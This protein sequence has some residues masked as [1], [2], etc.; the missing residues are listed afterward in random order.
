V[1]EMAIFE[2]N[3][4]E[5][6]HYV[7]IRLEDESVRVEAGALSYL[8]GDIRIHS[9]AFPPLGTVV[10]SW[11]ANEAI[12]R[13]V[14]SG[15]GMI[16]LESSLGGYCVIELDGETWLLDRGAYWA[17]EGSVSIG[18][19][20]E[21][22]TR[23]ILAGEGPIYL[24]TRVRGYGKVALTT[25]GP[26]YEYQLQPGERVICDGSLVIARTGDVRFRVRR[27]TDNMLGFLTAGEGWVRVY[28]GTGKV[29][30]NPA[31]YWRYR[32]LNSRG[33][34]VNVAARATS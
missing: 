2:V 24:L 26:V 17:S 28:E 32:I 1:I 3:Q 15:T 5:G 14:Y 21:P 10:K 20:R 27:P 4:L 8:M 9:R 22:V 16:T 23:S 29:L 7:Q 30:M 19:H 12:Y 34:N 6:T 25:K 31:P 11:L 33:Q 18:Y 13:P